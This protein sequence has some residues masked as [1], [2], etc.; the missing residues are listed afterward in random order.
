M[1]IKRVIRRGKQ[2]SRVEL[3]DGTERV[4]PTTSLLLSDNKPTLTIVQPTTQSVETPSLSVQER[5]A[6]MERLVSLVIE[7]RSPSLIIC[8]DAG[9][10][11]TFMVRQQLQH[12][13]LNEQV[14]SADATDAKPDNKKKQLR[15]LFG[16][17]KKRNNTYIFVKGYSSPMGLFQILHDNR[18]SII[19][20]DDCDSVFKTPVSVNILKSALDS[21]D[22]R[23]VS[24]VSPAAEKMG[25]ESRFEFKGKIIFIS[26][27]PELD[28]DE[29]VKSRSFVIS[30]T[31]TRK[32]LWDRMMALLPN[33]EP[34]VDM[35]IKDEV[36]NFMG[37]N[38]D[39]FRDFN[40]RTFIKAVRIRTS[41]D[42]NWKEMVLKFA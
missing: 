17:D 15:R 5:F 40:M 10:G 9:I 2:N 23:I 30:V 38:I 33:I 1:E 20:F 39:K 34:K 13:G 26:N 19:V 4:V 25:L 21:Y 28:L 31:L 35:V 3:A 27:L 12:A 24:W 6:H 41:G 16:A 29:A 42:P 36:I 14:V 22:T 11:K 18:E 32:E 37:F 7:G 8:G